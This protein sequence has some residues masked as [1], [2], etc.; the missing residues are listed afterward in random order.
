MESARWTHAPL[1]PISLDFCLFLLCALPS[2]QPL[3]TSH[4]DGSDLPTSRYQTESDLRKLRKVIGWLSLGYDSKLR[5]GMVSLANMQLGNFVF[6][7]LYALS[8]LVPP[9]S[10]FFMLLE[11]YGLQ[12]QHLSLHSIMLVAIFVHF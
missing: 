6:F 12:L 10:F 1:A 5:C 11:P 9:L 4:G 2:L 8:G 7:S 3:S